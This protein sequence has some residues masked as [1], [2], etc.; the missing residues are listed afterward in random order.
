VFIRDLKRSVRRLSIVSALLFVACPV[1]AQPDRNVITD[2]RFI[3]LNRTEQSIVRYVLENRV[4]EAY[5]VSRWISE[6]EKLMDLDLFASVSITAEA[7]ESGIGLTY[8]F[9][10]LPSFLVFPAMKRTDQDGLL[11]GPG[12]VF[13]NMFGLGIHQ[14][15]MYRT[16]VAP[17]PFRAKEFLSWTKVRRSSGFPLESDLTVNAFNSYNPLKLYNERS[18]YSLLNFLSPSPG[19]VMESFPSPRSR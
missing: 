16:T 10:E 7:R 9:V 8:T 3:G 6:R 14:E 5:S 2:I 13:M 17:D 11:M 19:P 18:L 4:G 1:T 15:L 12:I